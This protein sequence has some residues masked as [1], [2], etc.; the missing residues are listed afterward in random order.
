MWKP[1]PTPAW[2]LPTT[3]AADPYASLIVTVARNRASDMDSFDGYSFHAK[4]S[5]EPKYDSL[6]PEF[7]FANNAEFPVKQNPIHRLTEPNFRRARSCDNI[8]DSKSNDFFHGIK[9]QPKK[10]VIGFHFGRAF[11]TIVDKEGFK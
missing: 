4:K 10:Q 8:L 2:K 11:E 9:N 1:R 6:L 7:C 3:E 5:M